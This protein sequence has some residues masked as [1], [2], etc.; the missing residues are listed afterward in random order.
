MID[1]SMIFNDA[2]MKHIWVYRNEFEREE[3]LVE[4][5]IVVLKFWL[6]ISKEEQLRRFQEREATSYKQYKITAED[7]RNREKWEA[8]E[9][10]V[11]D[12]VERTSTEYAPWHLIEAN[13]K[14]HARIKVLKTLCDRLERALER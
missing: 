11:N 6:H 1:L 7:Y 4:H 2:P 10:A 8:Y 12:M 13:D 3:Q 9:I 5:G 14:Y